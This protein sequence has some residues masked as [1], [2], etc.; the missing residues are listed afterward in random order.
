MRKGFLYLVV[1][2]DWH[3]RKVLSLAAVQYHGDG[4]L[5][6]GPGRGLGEIWQ[7]GYLQ[8]RPGEPVYQFR[9]HECLAGEQH[10][11]LHGRAWT[12]DGQRVYRAPLAP[13]V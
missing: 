13:R 12:L 2:M 5:R 7:T 11:Y 6:L 4:F 3:S 10:P 8:H 1:I 9:F